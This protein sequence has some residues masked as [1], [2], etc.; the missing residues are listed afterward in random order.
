[1]MMGDKVCEMRLV[2]GNKLREVVV[3][4]KIALI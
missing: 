4:G 2:V 3:I 1:M